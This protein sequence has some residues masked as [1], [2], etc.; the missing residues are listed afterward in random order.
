M[1]ILSG[2]AN[3]ALSIAC[4]LYVASV[5]S[6]TFTNAPYLYIFTKLYKEKTKEQFYKNVKPHKIK[7]CVEG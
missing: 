7:L 2:V 4:P 1:R 6:N 3:E 5:A